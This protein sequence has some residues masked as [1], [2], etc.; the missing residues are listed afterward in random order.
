MSSSPKADFLIPGGLLVLS[1]VPVVA[2]T[3]RVAQLAGDAEITADNARF[4]AAPL[5]VM[6]HIVS[7]VIYSLLG[8]FQFAPGFRRRQPRWHRTAGR[9]LIPCGLIVALSALWMTQVF[10]LGNFQGPL[11]AD[12]D[13]CTLYAIRLVVASAMALFLCLG[14]TTILKRD[15]RNHG[16]W[17]IRAY[18]LGLGAGTQALTHIP[19]F[20]FPS[21]RGELARTLCMAAGWAINAAVAEWVITRES[22][23]IEVST[24]IQQKSPT[25]ASAPVNRF[26][27]PA[28]GIPAG[29]A[30]GG[31]RSAQPTP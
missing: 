8:A 31:P 2:G 30:L 12:F 3:L 29:S 23:G 14:V 17:M 22:R 24:T 27:P 20:L 6:L 16:A 10:P 9:V 25:M 11:V 21:I 5:P 28:G 18:A 19:W 7:S 13:G 15:F 26:S 4:F 1:F